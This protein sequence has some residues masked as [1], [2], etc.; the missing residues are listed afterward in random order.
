MPVLLVEDNKINQK[1]AFFTLKKLG[2]EV[3]IAENGLD[4]VERF[5]DN[6]FKIVLMDIQMPI[7]NGFDATSK[8]RALERVKN[9]QPSLI[10]AISANTIKEDIEKCFLVGMNEYI[11][12]PFSPEKLIQ[13]IKKHIEVQLQ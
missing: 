11:S 12:K 8:I 3:E 2:F 9:S 10:I 7:M 1:I 5:Q 6:E 4:A 13:V